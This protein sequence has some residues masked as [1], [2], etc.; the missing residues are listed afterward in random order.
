M[1]NRV[2]DGTE[3]DFLGGFL[4]TAGEKDAKRQDDEVYKA[5]YAHKVYLRRERVGA[6]GAEKPVHMRVGTEVASKLQNPSSKLQRSSKSQ[7]PKTR[8]A[9]HE[10]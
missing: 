8:S 4:S 7:I 2:L 6:E 10:R 9:F 3:I 5:I 1:I